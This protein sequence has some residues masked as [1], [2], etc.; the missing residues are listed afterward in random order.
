MGRVTAKIK[1]NQFYLR[2]QNDQGGKDE[3]YLLTL[4]ARIDRTVNDAE[5]PLTERRE[6]RRAQAAS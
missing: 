2:E 4:F 5:V 1:L 3:P 6:G